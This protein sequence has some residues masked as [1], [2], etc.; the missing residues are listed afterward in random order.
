MVA[1]QQQQYFWVWGPL[2]EAAQRLSGF[3][4]KKDKS[5]I[6]S[7]SACWKHKT[8][9]GHVR[10]F[11]Q[12]SF[13]SVEAELI[14]ALVSPR[15]QSDGRQT[16]WFGCFLHNWVKWNGTCW[17]W[18]TRSIR[19][20]VS[21]LSSTYLHEHLMED[22]EL[23]RRRLSSSEDKCQWFCDRLTFKPAAAGHHLHLHI[24]SARDSPPSPLNLYTSY[25]SFECW[26]VLLFQLCF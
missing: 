24:T 10:C 15:W 2:R 23:W 22:G 21:E 5:L 14:T 4:L 20:P 6:F 8:L 26:R 12:P 1:K 18:R 7:C 17:W 13:C 16:G 25:S 11:Y 9:N 3:W 19:L